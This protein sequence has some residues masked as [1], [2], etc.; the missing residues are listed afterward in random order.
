MSAADISTVKN[1]VDVFV[2]FL[3]VAN[4][5]WNAII[6]RSMAN[7]A[8]IETEQKAREELNKRVIKLEAHIDNAPNHNHLGD[9]HTRINELSGS[10]SE[11]VGVMSGVQRSLDRV[12]TKLINEG[13]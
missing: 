13:K 3:V 2:A 5:I 1:W 11:L 7:K 8:A 10:V 12:E 4:M 9:I 6:Q